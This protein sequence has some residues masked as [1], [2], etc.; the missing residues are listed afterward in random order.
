MSKCE[1]CGEPCEYENCADC[2]DHGDVEY[3]CC[4][5]CGKD[6]SEDIQAKAYDQAKDRMKYGH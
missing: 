5:I 1:S 2:C 6:V 4:L 3:P